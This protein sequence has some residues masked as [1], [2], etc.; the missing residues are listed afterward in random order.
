[1]KDNSDVFTSLIMSAQVEAG[2]KV[3][4]DWNG[5][6]AEGQ[7]SEVKEG[8]VTVT[9]KRSND[10]SKTGSASDPAVH[11]E[12]SGNDVVKLA[13]ELDVEKKANGE[14]ADESNGLSGVAEVAENKEEKANDGEAEPNEKEQ[15]RGEDESNRQDKSSEEEGVNGQEKPTDNTATEDKKD[16]NGNG[17]ASEGDKAVETKDI[18]T[19]DNKEQNGDGGAKEGDEALETNDAESEKSGKDEANDKEKTQEKVEEPKAKS[20]TKRKAEDIEGDET[21]DEAADIE[22]KEQGDASKK[23]KTTNGT[24][25]ATDTPKRGP[26]RPRGATVAK[27]EKRA[28]AAGGRSLRKT[29]SQAAAEAK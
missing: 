26:G 4:W 20:G 13:S 19:E 7:A 17:A 18:K 22:G 1:M 10:I 5:S 27:K 11:I 3:S 24:A 15:S 23:Q 9:S 25:K 2:D 16:Q 12:R 8:E 21:K 14:G 29:R 28:P 6:K